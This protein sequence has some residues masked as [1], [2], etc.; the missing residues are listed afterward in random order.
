[1]LFLNAATNLSLSHSFDFETL[2]FSFTPS[3]YL[4]AVSIQTKGVS[5]YPFATYSLFHIEIN[6]L[7]HFSKHIY[8]SYV[9]FFY[10][11]LYVCVFSHLV[12]FYCLT[13][14]NHMLM[15]ITSTIN[16]YSNKNIQG[17]TIS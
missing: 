13:N 6:C 7:G 1:M 3:S 17:L 9:Y 5:V 2:F 15:P 16:I 12:K 14:V 11:S 4:T 8:N 10:T